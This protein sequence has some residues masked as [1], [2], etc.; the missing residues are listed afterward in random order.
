ME[1]CFLEG[2]VHEIF[3]EVKRTHMSGSAMSNDI[4]Y[5][6]AVSE[7]DDIDVYKVSVWKDSLPFR[8]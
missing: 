6:K 8:T 4:A 7:G 3:L 2:L 1:Y 5:L